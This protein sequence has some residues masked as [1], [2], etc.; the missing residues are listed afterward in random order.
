MLLLG[1]GERI[2]FIGVD[3][4]EGHESTENRKIG[5]VPKL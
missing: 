5:D 1:N 4:P 3:A 2:S